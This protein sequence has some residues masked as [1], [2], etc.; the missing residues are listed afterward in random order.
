M[1]LSQR[2][3]DREPN[4]PYWCKSNFIWGFLNYLGL[5]E[6][7]WGYLKPLGLFETIWGYLKPFGAIWNYLGLFE[8]FW[9]YLRLLGESWKGNSGGVE[10][11]SEEKNVSLSLTLGQKFD[12]FWGP[13]RFFWGLYKSSKVSGS[14]E[15]T[16][17]KKKCSLSLTLHW[18]KNLTFLLWPWGW[19]DPP[20][21]P[22]K[23]A[24]HPMEPTYHVWSQ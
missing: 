2:W 12:R 9:G 8:T 15:E 24:E 10:A 16:I 5:F 20:H 4:F 1:I 14:G 22:I 17:S 3:K 23:F 19:S 13:C 18:V 11:I 6:T 7:I 21:F